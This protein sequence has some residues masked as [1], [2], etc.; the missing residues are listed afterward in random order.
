MSVNAPV[1]F[2][3]EQDRL[4]E[5][6]F[7]RFFIHD[8]VVSFL[9]GCVQEPWVLVQLPQ[10]AGAWRQRSEALGLRGHALT[11]IPRPPMIWP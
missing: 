2:V 7:C 5:L 6:E 4:I 8:Q 9:S 10:L 11:P 1:S 3:G